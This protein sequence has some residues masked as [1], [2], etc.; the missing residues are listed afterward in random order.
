MESNI[1]NSTLFKRLQELRVDFAYSK[2]LFFA[3]HER[4]KREEDNKQRLKN[5][6]EILSIV[7][8]VVTLSSVAVYF[9]QKYQEQS[10]I[11][12]GLLSI[13]EITISVIL[14]TLKNDKLQ[15]EYNRVA[16]GYLDLYKKAK[17]LEAKV[18]DNTM[19]LVELSE[20]IEDL[21]FQQ[22]KLNNTKLHPCDQDF[23]KAK[24]N[25]EEGKST[26]TEKDFKN[27]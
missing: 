9:S 6:L 12:I 4:V 8:S 10:V 17:N 22:S 25:I 18:V 26:Y 16:Y 2:N 20:R 19:G 5:S 1:L 13:L 27:T 15:E 11:I 23:N 24:S 21:T 7:I 3:A 14:L